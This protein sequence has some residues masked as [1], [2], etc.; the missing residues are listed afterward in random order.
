M[1]P[2]MCSARTALPTEGSNANRGARPALLT[3]EGADRGSQTPGDKP[4]RRRGQN[5]QRWSRGRFLHEEG[6]KDDELV[7]FSFFR[8]VTWTPLPASPCSLALARGPH[9]C[10]CIKLVPV[11][12]GCSASNAPPWRV[13]GLVTRCGCC[14]YRVDVSNSP[15]PPIRP[16]THTHTHLCHA[17]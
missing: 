17:R 10:S 11:L 7:N 1:G 3:G 13:R 5:T 15:P 12:P 8:S 14:G 9:C 2:R 4:C 6:D 16:P